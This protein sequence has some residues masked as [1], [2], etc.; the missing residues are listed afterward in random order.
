MHEPE[1]EEQ[2]QLYFTKN[3]L[4]LMTTDTGQRAKEVSNISGHGIMDQLA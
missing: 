4:R 1:H 2:L 3:E